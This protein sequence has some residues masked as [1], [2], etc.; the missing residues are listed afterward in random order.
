MQLIYGQGSFDFGNT[1]SFSEAQVRVYHFTS[2]PS[3][4]FH[5]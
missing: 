4:A 1:S 2:L 3:V 5:E